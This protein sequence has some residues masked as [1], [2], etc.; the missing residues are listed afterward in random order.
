[1][2]TS[3]T[4]LLDELK[5]EYEKQLE[6]WQ[7]TIE[8]WDEIWRL[9]QEEEW[10]QLETPSDRALYNLDRFMD[11]YFLTDG[12]PDP[13]K[14][15]EPIAL[16]NITDEQMMAAVHDR[17]MFVSGLEIAVGGQGPDR[18]MCIGWD[19]AAVCGLAGEIEN[20]AKDAQRK[21]VQD[22]W[23]RAMQSHR[24]FVESLQPTAEAESA[25]PPT[26]GPMPLTAARG[27]FV[28]Q[29][30]AVMEKYPDHPNLAN[31]ALN[32][33]DSPANNGETLRAA[34]DLG[35]FQGTAVLS[36]SQPVVDWFVKYYDK[37]A[38]ATAG[39]TAPASPSGTKGAKRKA[40][41]ESNSQ[42]PTKQRKSNEPHPPGRILM[43]MRG[44][45]L[46]EGLICP[47]VQEGYLEFLDNSCTKFTGVID[48]PSV[49]DDLEI[50]GFRVSN[51]AAI[52]PPPW[53]W[54][55]PIVQHYPAADQYPISPGQMQMQ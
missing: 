46:I 28:V 50:E 49:G 18:T 40:V 48:I 34:V 20:I 24:Q 5:R 38:L 29:C 12:Q 25:A 26:S 13:A 15:P 55:W 9:R 44:R 7:Q 2:P 39:V 11:H 27:C 3:V 53:T 35:V 22:E 52:E 41:E 33:S 36:F 42:R 31:I 32:I 37:S 14:K 17:V 51:D 16:Y 30:K 6:E 1:M 54:F 43:R 45:E 19:R 21:R 8:N 23:E 47:D 4:S 10:A